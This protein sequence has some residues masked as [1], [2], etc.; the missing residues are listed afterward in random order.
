MVYILPSPFRVG[1]SPGSLYSRLTAPF[2]TFHAKRDERNG[3]FPVARTAHAGAIVGHE[4]IIH[5]GMGEE[6]DRM[7][8]SSSSSSFA[9]NSYATYRK[10]TR[11]RSLSD[12]WAFDLLTLK[13]KERVVYPQLA[14]SYH[15][16][17]GREDGTIS[18]FGGFQQDN[19]IP[20]E[21]RPAIVDGICITFPELNYHHPLFSRPS[22]LFSTT[23]Y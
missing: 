10:S 9:T 1:R 22:H 20:G 23:S 18:A 5:G 14:R 16:L 15:S 19:N 8:S 3:N 6:N 11:W 2:L 7:P 13:W 21:V 4:L 17:V 12:V